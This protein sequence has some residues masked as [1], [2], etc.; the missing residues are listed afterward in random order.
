M[1]DAS[2]TQA[3]MDALI[4][5]H[6]RAEEAGDLDAIVGDETLDDRVQIARFL[7]SVM[8]VDQGVHSGLADSRV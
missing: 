1:L 5:D 2:V 8:A 4:D 7:G 3:R 6:Y